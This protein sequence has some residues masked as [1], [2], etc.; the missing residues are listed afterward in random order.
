MISDGSFE[1]IVCALSNDKHYVET[2]MTLPD[3]GHTVCKSCLPFELNNNTKCKI[4]DTRITRNLKNDK[5]SIVAN[6]YIKNSLYNLMNILKNQTENQIKKLK[7]CVNAK[8]DSVEAHVK[9]I[10]NEIEIKIQS[11]KQDLDDLEGKLKADLMR[12]RADLISTTSKEINAVEYKLQDF[13][14][15]LEKIKNDLNQKKNLETNEFY[16]FQKNLIELNRIL[17]DFDQKKFQLKFNVS[18]IKI[19]EELIGN[20]FYSSP[21]NIAKMRSI[22]K[23]LQNFENEEL[24]E[25]QSE[26]HDLCM[27]PN[28]T[29]VA[30]DWNARSLVQYDLNFMTIKVVNC[31]NNKKIR[32]NG[33]AL[34]SK[35]NELF[36]TDVDNHQILIT[37]FDLNLI[38][39]IESKPGLLK[40]PAGIYS[41][42][43]GDLYV[44]EE[45][46]HQIQVFDE[47][48]KF[49]KS[50][51]FDYKPWRIKMSFDR[52]FV[53]DLHSRIAYIYDLNNWEVLLKFDNGFDRFTEIDSYF[54]SISANMQLNCFNLDGGEL[55]CKTNIMST[56]IK[57]LNDSFIVY[58]N[59]NLFYLI[60]NRK[61]CLKLTYI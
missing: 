1:E 25:I 13:D 46:S 22:M 48:L 60:T 10:E 15:N 34:N 24:I 27:L 40:H 39:K 8:L 29:F 52:A 47:D 32:P 17:F 21:N 31:F 28:D 7:N 35:K 23:K 42:K 61:K 44:C 20:I 57:N 5:E 54:Y 3:C 9:Y 12:Y 37:D 50:I 56:T 33:L 36:I 19:K 45:V 58:L 18:K 30:A 6:I 41:H 38:K 51:N 59:E 26:T 55:V 14:K 16:D 53:I 2:P 49:K 4:C 11:I 43:S